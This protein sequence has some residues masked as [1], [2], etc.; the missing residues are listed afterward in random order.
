VYSVRI[1]YTV[2][3]TVKMIVLEGH[4][5]TRQ[6]WDDGRCCVELFD[7][8]DRLTTAFMAPFTWSITVKLKS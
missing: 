5:V 2:D 6:L 1:S 3:D 7:E 8:Q 4:R